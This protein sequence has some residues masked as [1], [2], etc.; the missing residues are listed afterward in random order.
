MSRTIGHGTG[1]G[2]GGA[3]LEIARTFVV[4]R[5]KSFLESVEDLL[6][7]SL[8]LKKLEDDVLCLGN[9]EIKKKKSG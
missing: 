8:E 7:H 9:L 3:H 2:K 4:Q 1:E 6:V 5:N